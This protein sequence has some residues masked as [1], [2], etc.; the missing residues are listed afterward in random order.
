MAKRDYYDV[1]SVSKSASSDEV[2]KAYRKAAMDFHPDRNPGNKEAEEKFK[3]A[4][5]AYQVLSDSNNRQKYDQFGHAAFEQGAGGFNGFG[6]FSGFEDLFSDIFG[7]FFGASSG[8][9]SR[10]RA[11]RD[12]RYNLQVEFEEAIF[13]LEKEVSITRGV[14]CDACDGGG[15]AS[16]SKPES[17]KQCGGSGQI[18]MQ[19]GFFSI[20][21][22]CSVC[23]GR[24]QLIID[25]CKVCKG[26]G[27]KSVDSKIKVKVPAGIDHGQRLKLRGEGEVGSVGGPAGDLYVEILIKDHPLFERQDTEIICAIPISYSTAVLGD[28]IEVPT[29]EGTVSMKIPPGTPTGKIFR[30]R[31]KGVPVL[32]SNR[33]G[34]QHVKV[35]IRVPK[36]IAP[37]HRQVLEELRQHEDIKMDEDPRGFLEKMKDMFA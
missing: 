30:L 10:G 4:T 37:E 14:F 11:G 9:R 36:K 19:Q 27:V 35:I 5:E 29:L 6:D 24:G 26:T 32:G 17:C 1:L 13:G 7:S 20:T 16:G 25:P 23:G 15:A 18:A 33:R 12:L 3:E 21:R 34:D 8:G 28:E 31:G 22:T 2:K